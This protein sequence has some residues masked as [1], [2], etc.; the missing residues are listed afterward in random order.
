MPNKIRFGEYLHEMR[1]S[2]VQVSYS[3]LMPRVEY[4]AEGNEIPY[5]LPPIRL[6]GLDVYRLLAP[7][8]GTRFGK[9]LRTV[10]PLA[11]YLAA[12]QWIILRTPLAD[13]AIIGIGIFAVMAGL[14]LF[15]E[16]LKLG[17]M[18]F[19]ELIGN[20]LP[21]K[22]KLPVVLA[23]IFAL[24]VGVT[25]A[26]PA[27]GA[28]QVAGALVDPNVAPHLSALLTKWTTALVLAV[29][30]GV[31]LAA[32]LGT[33]RFINGWSLKPLIYAALV[34]T[35]LLTVYVHLRPDLSTVM[36][37]AWDLGAVTTGP[38]TVPLVLA[39]GIGVAAAVGRGSAPLAGFGIVTLAS[40]LPILAVLILALAL[41]AAAPVDAVAAAAA[42]AQAASDT[43]ARWWEGP[44]MDATVAGLRAIV[45][46]VV[47]LYL[48]LKFVARQ[49]LQDAPTVRYGIGLTIV[50]MIIF[51]LGLAFGLAKLGEQS[52]RLIP[53]TFTEI[54]AMEGSPLFHFA[55]GILITVA[56]AWLLGFGATLAEPALNALGI[57]VEN[58]TNGA[59]KKSS[60]M[61]A[62]AFGVG[63]GIALGIVKIVVQFPLTYLLI[64][65][66]GIALAL[67]VFSSEEYVNVAWDSAGVTTGP[68]TVPLVLAIGLG[69]GDATGA[70]EGFG[71]LA[72][73]SMGPI[74]SVLAFGLYVEWKSRKAAIERPAARSVPEAVLS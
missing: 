17:L 74:L 57:T 1:V 55:I 34:P 10:A 3:N 9:Q 33:L 49:R 47:F 28:L 56:F 58:L 45:P 22:V 69:L 23:I 67:T 65:L 63:V 68:V 51:N 18:P 72:A 43:P 5:R 62:V 59:F 32:V 29:G 53:G 7:Y 14:M 66:Y 52:G 26:E 64:P 71:I 19:A 70:I 40:L 12:F 13:A 27:V 6:R 37:L 60:L 41:A 24:G 39:L 61:Y 4:D 11:L 8:L 2:S 21:R 25:F 54:A 38:V 20:A 44:V 50:G 30:A 73:A 42:P 46:L 48:V 31:G 35:L 15:M 36:G 16:G